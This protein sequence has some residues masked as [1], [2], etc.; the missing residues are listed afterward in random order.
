MNDIIPDAPWLHLLEP[1]NRAWR[2][3]QILKGRDP[4]PYIEKQLVESGS[5]P[6]KDVKQ[7]SDQ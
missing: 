2:E 7:A 5:W 6:P 1:E 4:D 3:K